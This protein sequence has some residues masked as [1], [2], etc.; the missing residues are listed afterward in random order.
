MTA[1]A[2]VEELRSYQGR[3][4]AAVDAHEVGD[5]AELGAILFALDED[6]E[7]LVDLLE[8]EGAAL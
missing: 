5:Q 7:G 2:L 3:I 1:E 4:A 6:L 8:R